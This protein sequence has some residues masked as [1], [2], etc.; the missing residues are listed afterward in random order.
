MPEFMSRLL[1][2]IDTNV[3][4]AMGSKGDA[5]VKAWLDTVDDDQYRISPI[6]YQ[7]MRRGREKQLAD[8]IRKN[9]D[10]SQVVN[11][12]AAL[13]RF[14]QDFEDRQVPITMAISAEVARM[15]GAKSKNYCDVV[16]AATAR[17][18]GLIVVTRNVK[19]F[20]G[21]DVDL[22]NPFD[23]NPQVQHV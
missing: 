11:Y 5:N 13:D 2:L 1:Y 18:H 20:T 22:L 3:F 9:Q 19:D 4:S 12:L 16:L 23:L 17:I 15:L 8:L 7:E 6:V 14:E 21:R 10:T